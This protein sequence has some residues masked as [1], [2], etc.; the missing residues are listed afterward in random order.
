MSHTMDCLT[1]C[2]LVR[3]VRAVCHVI[4][5]RLLGSGSMF[6][7][8]QAHK[9]KP[10][11]PSRRS[12]HC[13]I[14]CTLMLMFLGAFF[15]GM[16]NRRA[17]PTLG[18]CSVFRM[19]SAMARLLYPRPVQGPGVSRLRQ[20]W[21]A[22]AVHGGHDGSIALLGADFVYHQSTRVRGYESTN[23]TNSTVEFYSPQGGDP[24]SADPLSAPCDELHYGAYQAPVSFCQ[25]GPRPPVPDSYLLMHDAPAF[26][27]THLNG[28]YSPNMVSPRK[29]AYGHHEAHVASTTLPL[30]GPSYW[31]EM[32]DAMMTTRL[33]CPGHLVN[34]LHRKKYT[35]P[36]PIMACSI[37]RRPRLRSLCHAM[38]KSF[39]LLVMHGMP[40]MARTGTV[41][42]ARATESSWSLRS[43]VVLMLASTPPSRA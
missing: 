35:G 2:Y 18:R 10:R 9:G 32:G 28:L 30:K 21:I 29:L 5:L 33:L 16:V 23:S 36:K 11:T 40:I 12:S 27:Q 26:Q 13:L 37:M 7:S 14:L 25:T 43:M 31:L 3:R 22:E 20:A 1:C 6:F 39:G 8:R 19:W 15:F 41:W 17:C 34:R 4:P 42:G 38:S 24:T